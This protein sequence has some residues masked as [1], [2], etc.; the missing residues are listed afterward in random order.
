MVLHIAPYRLISDIQKDFN[1]VFPFLKLEFFNPRQVARAGFTARQILPNTKKIGDSQLAIT[2][3]QIEIAENMKVKDLEKLLKDQFSLAVQ[4][5]RKSG[6][7]WLE[8]TMTD[9]WTLL[10]Q[11]THGREISTGKNV[12]DSPDDFD[13]TAMPIIKC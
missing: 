8:T 3:G 9:N 1:K 6:N 10:Q 2:D 7:L 5:F 4:V 13:L 11:N 12:K